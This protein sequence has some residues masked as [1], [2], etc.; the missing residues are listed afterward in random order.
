MYGGESFFLSCSTEGLEVLAELPYKYMPGDFCIVDDVI[1]AVS[2]YGYERQ[3]D[4]ITMDGELDS[5][6]YIF[7]QKERDWSNIIN[8]PGLFPFY[9]DVIDDDHIYGVDSLWKTIYYFEKK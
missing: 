6:I 2:L 8:E 7:E 5:A 1:Y 9:L 4:R 3:I